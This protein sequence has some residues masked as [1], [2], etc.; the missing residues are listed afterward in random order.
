MIFYHSFFSFVLDAC[1][2]LN[3]T[4]FARLSNGQICCRIDTFLPF[5]IYILFCEI[6]VFLRQIGAGIG[7]LVWLRKS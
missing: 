6:Y 2:T 3:G 4:P 5:S 1:N 7:K